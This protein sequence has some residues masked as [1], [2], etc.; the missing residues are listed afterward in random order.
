MR[1]VPLLQKLDKADQL[2]LIEHIKPINY[3]DGDY[4]IRQG[5]AGKSFF[6]ITSG[7]AQ[8]TEKLLSFDNPKGEAVEQVLTNLYD[9]HVFGEMALID[10]RPRTAS[11]RASGALQCMYLTKEDM[12]RAIPEGSFQR[13]LNSFAAEKNEVRRDRKKKRAVQQMNKVGDYT[14]YLHSVKYCWELYSRTK[15][16]YN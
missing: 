11:V 5:E 12:Q 1:K 10:D 13:L 3:T 14:L 7:Q 6:M 15:N 4:V 9:G 16:L 2:A 8:V